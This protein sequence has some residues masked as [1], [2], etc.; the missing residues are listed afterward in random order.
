MKVEYKMF[1]YL[2]IFFIPLGPIYYF[3]EHA[4]GGDDL[5]GFIALILT[6]LLSLLIYFYLRVT[7]RQFSDRPEDNPAGEIADHEGDYGFFTPYSWW[8]LWLGLSAAVIFLGLAVG[9]WIV[10]IGMGIGIVSICGW[11][12]EHFKGEYAN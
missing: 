1:L 4:Y 10:I 9:W 11:T 7:A 6:A 3:W 12:F 8:P 5:V 2:G